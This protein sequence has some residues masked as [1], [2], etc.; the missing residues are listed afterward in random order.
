MIIASIGVDMAGCTVQTFASVLLVAAVGALVISK[1]INAGLL[2]Y[3]VFVVGD[4]V[5]K[6]KLLSVFWINLFV[7]EPF[8]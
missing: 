7:S 1:E 5:I 6:D 3:E 8:A 2:F 4:G